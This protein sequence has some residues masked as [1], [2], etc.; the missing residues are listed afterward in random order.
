MARIDHTNCTHPRTPAGR[1]ACRA[2]VAP[3]VAPAASS[4]VARIA[5]LDQANQNRPTIDTP[6]GKI[7]VGSIIVADV[8][9]GSPERYVV[10]EISDDI[11][12]GYAGWEAEGR[13][14]YADQVLRRIQF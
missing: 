7:A 13:W 4:M 10:L 12:N 3:V 11:K 6:A 14:G 1:R 9:G 8:R 2:G 5:E